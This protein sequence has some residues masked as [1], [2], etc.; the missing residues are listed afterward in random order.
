MDMVAGSIDSYGYDALLG[1]V[2]AYHLF[3]DFVGGRNADMHHKGLEQG[4]LT[5]RTL[6]DIRG[7]SPFLAGESLSIADLYLAPVLAYV[8]LT[9]H[10]NEFL[11]DDARTADWWRRISARE[12]FRTTAPQG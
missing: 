12:S 3:P 1:G 11:V 6:M 2:V 5:M 7:G 10:A 9:P 4:R 8:A